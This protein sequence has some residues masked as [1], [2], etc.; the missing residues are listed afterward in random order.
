MQLELILARLRFHV[1]EGLRF[2]LE[3][4]RWRHMKELVQ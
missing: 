1:V 3:S 4:R 2:K